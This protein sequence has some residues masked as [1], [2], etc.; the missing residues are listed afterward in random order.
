MLQLEKACHMLWLKLV[1]QTVALLLPVGA[2]AQ[3]SFLRFSECRK[4]QRQEYPSVPLAEKR[5]HIA[6]E[7]MKYYNLSRCGPLG[8]VFRIWYVYIYIYIYRSFECIGCIL[9][10]AFRM[11]GMAPTNRITTRMPTS[12]KLVMLLPSLWPSPPASAA[13]VCAGCPCSYAVA[14]ADHPALQWYRCCL[15]GCASGGGAVWQTAA[16]W[17]QFAAL[18]ESLA[19][20]CPACLL[21]TCIIQ[22]KG[23][24]TR[25]C[26]ISKL[27]PMH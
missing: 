7:Y 14:A 6:A 4:M 10:S 24:G 20:C 9:M 25:M 8:Q 13:D 15:C 3:H 22:Q 18:P 23:S 5:V 11:H 2:R 17:L 16:S 21:G 26:L 1:L 12:P 19:G 27:T